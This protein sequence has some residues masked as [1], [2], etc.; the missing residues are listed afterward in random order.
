MQGE[1]YELEPLEGLDVAQLEEVSPVSGAVFIPGTV[2]GEDTSAGRGS[3]ESLKKQP[4][5]DFSI[6]NKQ[7]QYL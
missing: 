5:E 1:R 2:V 6:K 7:F 3:L 4:I